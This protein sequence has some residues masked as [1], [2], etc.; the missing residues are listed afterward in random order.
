[1]DFAK[2]I[3]EIKHLAVGYTKHGQ[4]CKIL[5][6]ISLTICSGEL[7]AL[8]GINGSGKSTLLKTILNFQ[9]PCAGEI[10]FNE[11]KIETYSLAQLAQQIS[12]V[13]TEKIDVPQMTVFELLSLGRFPYT[14]WFGALSDDDKKVIEQVILQ[15]KLTDLISKKIYEISDGEKQRA[16]IARA[17][18]QDTDLIVLDEPTAF[19]DIKSRIETV[20]LLKK[21]TIECNKTILYSTHDLNIA[22]QTADKIWVITDSEVIEGAPEDLVLNGQFSRIFSSEN[23]S[24]DFE[25]GD[26]IF[27]LP[28]VRNIQL[29]GE[30]T[31]YNW[32][33]RALQ[34]NGFFVSDTHCALAVNIIANNNILQWEL[35]NG[36]E[37]YI[38]TS[39][40]DLVSILKSV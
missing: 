30:G 25:K 21:L 22:L 9:K 29:Q 23:I 37:K 36:N 32:T 1:M 28:H 14:H 24:F 27:H 12:F 8:V 19:L 11:K 17:L 5:N 35:K 10:F 6:D 16:M 13:S 3:I 20:Q 40:Y 4:M 31:T 34:R 33:K 2:N 26:F 7:V 18:V 15:T 39:I 38:A